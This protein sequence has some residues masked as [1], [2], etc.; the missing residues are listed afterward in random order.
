MRRALTL[1]V[2]AVLLASLPA[3]AQ[4]PDNKVNFNI[5]GGY[6]FALSQVR[7]QLGDG[8]NFAVGLWFNIN[9]A[10]AFQAE[11][12]FNGLGTKELQIP[13][14]P[15]P[16]L[17]ATNQAFFADMN[18]QYGDFN[19][20]FKPKTES[21]VKPYIVAGIGVYYRPIKV[22]TPS[23]GYMPPYC[24][25]WWYYCWPGGLVPVDKIVAARSATN[26]GIDVGGGMNFKVADSVSL[27][28]ETRYHYIWGP[29][30]KDA[31]GVSQGK[32][33]GQF[34]PITFGVRF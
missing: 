26:F 22:T 21:A 27:Y 29:E 20:V 11:Y 7:N 33:N 3:M 4:N 1:A 12:S 23:V 31:A 13:V 5:G 8:Y 9:P 34:L 14:A 18:M 30:V 16:G 17:P 28:F 19:L 32:A 10:L 2:L 25:P 15:G 6:T 24:D